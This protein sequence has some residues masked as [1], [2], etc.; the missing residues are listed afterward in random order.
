MFRG[1]YVCVQDIDTTPKMVPLSLRGTGINGWFRGGSATTAPAA[2][3][4]SL[5]LQRF[6]CG[7]GLEHTAGQ[8]LVSAALLTHVLIPRNAYSPK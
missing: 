4:Q 6:I 3:C 5:V 8:H 2:G 1:M 7:G